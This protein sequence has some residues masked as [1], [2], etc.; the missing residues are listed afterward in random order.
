MDMGVRI[1]WS[2][3]SCP[4]ISSWSSKSHCQ[5]TCNTGS[6]VRHEPKYS[7]EQGTTQGHI[8]CSWDL[9]NI[10]E[11]LCRKRESLTRTL[12]SW[13][14]PRILAIHVPNIAQ[15]TSPLKQRQ[16]CQWMGACWCIYIHSKYVCVQADANDS[17]QVKKRTSL[18]TPRRS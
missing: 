2:S 17:R 13:H 12:T 9:F 16:V 7:M 3:F 15:E 6:T 5:R 1:G 14:K 4:V 10:S 11:G 8:S 18:H